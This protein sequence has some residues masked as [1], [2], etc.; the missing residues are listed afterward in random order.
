MYGTSIRLDHVIAN[1]KSI[2]LRPLPAASLYIAS[3]DAGGASCPIVYSLTAT[4]SWR[5]EGPVIVGN[6]GPAFDR[7]SAIRL[8]TFSGVVRISEEERETSYLDQL[9]IEATFADGTSQVVHAM[10][11]TV[12]DVDGEYLVMR[13]GDHAD[14]DFAPIRDGRIVRAVLLVKGYYVPEH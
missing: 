11:R 13:R 10:N 1:G 2:A 4:A 12:R 6:R 8:R 9:A 3:P 7:T 14:L 5:R